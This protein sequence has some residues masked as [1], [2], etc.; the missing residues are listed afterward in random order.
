VV[1]FFYILGI[2]IK[3]KPA[4]SV[5]KKACFFV[6]NYILDISVDKYV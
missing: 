6:G 4:K 3:A 1:L 5:M 2:A